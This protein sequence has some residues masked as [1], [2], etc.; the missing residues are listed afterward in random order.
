MPNAVAKMRSSR[1]EEE[2][3]DEAADDMVELTHEGAAAV[4]CRMLQQF[5]K[6][7]IWRQKKVFEESGRVF[8]Q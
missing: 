6:M 4:N 1:S 5:A 2:V 3:D 7:G 8:G